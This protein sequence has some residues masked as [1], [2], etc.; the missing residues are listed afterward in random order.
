M[1]NNAYG[2]DKWLKYN[3]LYSKALTSGLSEPL[4]GLFGNLTSVEVK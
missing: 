1:S 3:H 4:Q 2:A